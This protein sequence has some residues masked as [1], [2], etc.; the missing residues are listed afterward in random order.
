MLKSWI[1]VCDYMI[2]CTKWVSLYD[3]THHVSFLPPCSAVFLDKS[4][5]PKCVECGSI[6]IDQLYKRVF[7]LV[8]CEKCKKEIPEKYSLLTKTECKEVG[9]RDFHMPDALSKCSL[10]V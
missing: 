10:L 9:R 2:I 1:L 4:K 3:H 8:V 5:N 7:G 6:D